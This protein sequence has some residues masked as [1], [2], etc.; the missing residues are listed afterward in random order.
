[1]TLFPTMERDELAAWLRLALTPGIGNISARKL[2]VAFGLPQAV[3]GQTVAAF[4]PAL[5]YVVVKI[6]RW[7]FEKFKDALE[8]ETAVVGRSIPN[9]GCGTILPAA[10]PT[11]V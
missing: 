8:P 6:P 1:M 9:N 2:L 4:E 11:S 3:F 10:G 5:D 7:A